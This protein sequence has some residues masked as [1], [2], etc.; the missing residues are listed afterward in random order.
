MEATVPNPLLQPN[1]VV[2]GKYR[3][4]RVVGRGGMGAV[5][6]ATH[7]TL[8]QPVALKVLLR[9]DGS[10]AQ[11]FAREARLAAKLRS[12]H[13]CR[14][15]DVGVAEEG[16][17]YMV[18]EY[19]EGQ[20]LDALLRKRGRLGVEQALTYFMQMCE[21]VAEA[22]RRGIVHRD[23][24]LSNIFLEAREI[25]PPRMKVL[26][27]GISKQ[28]SGP[29]R[30]SK[31]ASL[32]NANIA[33]GSA[34]Y[35]APEQAMDASKVD[36]RADIWALGVVLYRMLSG[37]LPFEGRGF[38]EIIAKVVSED[39]PPLRDHVAELPQ[40]LDDAALRCLEKAPD[41][42]YASVEQLID[43]IGPFAPEAYR[44]WK[45]ALPSEAEIA[46]GTPSLESV[47]VAR[48]TVD[49]TVTDVIAAPTRTAATVVHD[50]AT[51]DDALT[52][53]A[54]THAASTSGAPVDVSVS[55]DRNA[56]GGDSSRVSSAAS[57][58]AL[59][60][61]SSW[62]PPAAAGTH[63]R[64]WMWGAA[65]LAFVV[66]GVL[67]WR[68]GASTPGDAPPATTTSPA[69]PSTADA[70]G[71]P[72]RPTAAAEPAEVSAVLDA[73]AR[74]AASAEVDPADPARPTV[75]RRARPGA[76]REAV[77]PSRRER[78]EQR[79][80]QT[81]PDAREPAAEDSSPTDP[82]DYQ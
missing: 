25:G 22:H 65:A 11:R 53:A 30:R 70:P 47:E 50:D 19:L 32:T 33:M 38:A 62:V 10:A 44:R 54:S 59:A 52:S 77:I 42:R 69:R 35:M 76:A 51:A 58:A 6:L 39:P 67:L 79:A 27:F 13:V 71:E 74:E 80:K 82:F 68:G 63:D 34:A 2:D 40:R 1:H 72:A 20:G 21:V 43:D 17:P 57:A 31:L 61:A 78:R 46:A 15:L 7:L 36:A 9:R 4:E 26:D 18:L 16:E 81:T 29:D 8:D 49:D 14:V 56:L 60:S 64:R 66:A 75:T 73:P 41:D 5:L 3:V 55:A 23:L 37:A 28:V 45:V 24:K 48:P 12:E